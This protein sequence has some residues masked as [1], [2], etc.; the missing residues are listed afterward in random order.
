MNWADNGNEIQN[1]YRP[2]G[3]LASRPQNKDFYFRE[4]VTWSLTSTKGL[5]ARWRAP[6]FIFDVNGM[7]CFPPT[8]YTPVTLAILN[9]EFGDYMLRLINPTIAFQV[10]DIARLPFKEPSDSRRACIDQLT[11]TSVH[12]TQIEDAHRENTYDFVAPPTWESGLQRLKMAKL[13]LAD[14]EKQIDGEIFDLYGIR[15]A[16]R[17]AI[18]AELAGEPLPEESDEI[19]AYLETSDME[20]VEEVMDHKELAVRWLSYATGIV[21]G[22]FDPGQPDAL[23]SAV[24][25]REQLA[26]GSLPAPDEDEFDQLVGSVQRFAYV[27]EEGGRHIFPAEVESALRNLS[28]KDGIAVL[29]EDHPRDLPALVSE[30]LRLMIGDD[31]AREVIAEGAGGDLRQFLSKK[32]FTDWHFKWYS[33]SRRKTAV[34]WPVQSANL[35]YGFVLFHEKIDETTLYVLQR[36]YLDYKL[37]GLRQRIG[38]LAAREQ[39]LDGS[40][41]K[42]VAR[43]IQELNGTL[44]EVET[45]AKTIDRIV[46]EGYEPQPNWIDDGVILR[47]APLWELIPIWSSEPK[48]Y[49]K[50]L[51]EGEYDW[52]HIA[53]NYWPER[54]R[55]ACR[56]N[57]S[58]A[59]AHGHPEWY[60]GD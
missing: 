32:Y 35:S 18:V 45:F 26:V 23:G 20:A 28:V 53:M 52:S 19:Q 56:E 2:S 15:N 13:R 43:E 10:G 1:F 22:R 37:N 12:T 41:R 59:I 36:E 24:Y 7:S 6:G 49:W 55:E 40:A 50:R 11:V 17:A 31:A 33:V 46:R 9:S 5:A 48:K 42:R 21:L 38:D 25:R 57:K 14:L 47:M 30:A 51:Q 3:R 58:Y 34:Y 16:D 27:D 39:S 54:V 60:E 44:E 4:G 29:D 8:E